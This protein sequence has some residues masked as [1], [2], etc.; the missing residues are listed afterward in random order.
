VGKDSKNESKMSNKNNGK[1]CASQNYN[2]SGN[3]TLKNQ[4][5]LVDPY[6]D[7]F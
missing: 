7:K 3:K 6:V 1:R 4:T 5:N 2:R